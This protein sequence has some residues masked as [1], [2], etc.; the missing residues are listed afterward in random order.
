MSNVE[1]SFLRSGMVF[2]EGEKGRGLVRI[3]MTGFRESIV[4]V[5]IHFHDDFVGGLYD[6]V[7]FSAEFL[8]ECGF[9]SAKDHRVAQPPRRHE[10]EGI[11]IEG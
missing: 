2:G 10:V 11:L 7:D 9:E 3:G 1:T 4:R 8:F 5:V 6:E